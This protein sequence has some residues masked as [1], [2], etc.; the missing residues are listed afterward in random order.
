MIL[1]NSNC[2]GRVETGRST[3]STYLSPAMLMSAQ[4]PLQGPFDV[5]ETHIS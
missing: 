1:D 4:R 3:V 2:F 5:L